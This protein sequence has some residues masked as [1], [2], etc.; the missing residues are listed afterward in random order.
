MPTPYGKQLSDNVLLIS[1]KSMQRFNE[2][3]V[4]VTKAEIKEAQMDIGGTEKL[5]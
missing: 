5:L 1:K 3:F 2:A 4:D